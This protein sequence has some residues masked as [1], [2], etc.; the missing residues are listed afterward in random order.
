MP[1]PINSKVDERRFLSQDIRSIFDA[2]V[3]V[4]VKRYFYHQVSLR[5]GSL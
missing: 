3:K 4:D 5:G 2:D 1:G